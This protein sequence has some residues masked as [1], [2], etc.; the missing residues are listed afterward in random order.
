MFILFESDQLD[1]IIPALIAAKQEF[2]AIVKAVRGARSKYATLEDYLCA[3]EPV[4]SRHGLTICQPEQC[5]V[6]E[7][8]MHV[9]DIA[10]ITTLYHTS[11]QFL[12]SAAPLVAARDLDAGQGGNK[13]Q[14]YGGQLTY[15]R[16]Y[17]IAALLGI[18]AENED[19][20]AE[21]LNGM[22]INR[23]P[24]A[25]KVEIT[26]TITKEQ[27]AILEDELKD[28][29]D[30]RARF[31]KSREIT[32]L[33]QLPAARFASDFRLIQERARQER[34]IIADRESMDE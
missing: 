20:D 33:T 4:L 1:E 18:T 19:D 14:A 26:P 3:V 24:T 28:L 16:R 13:F 5:M 34:E 29:P 23:R 11:G 6:D 21:S 8:S 15:R 30:V 2:P 27:A 32:T 10:L 9:T 17:A 7:A 31:L 22:N 12:R 25:P